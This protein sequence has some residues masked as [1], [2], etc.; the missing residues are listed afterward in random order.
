V[1]IFPT[2]LTCQGIAV[3][4]LC[5]L[6]AP[7]WAADDAA[8]PLAGGLPPADVT[9]TSASPLAFDIPMQPLAA[10]LERYAGIAHLSI[11][12]TSDMVRGRTSSPVQGR[13]SS[14]AALQRLLEG[15]GLV[16]DVHDSGAGK[17]Y[18]L[19]EVDKPAA[20]PAG[21]STLFSQQGYPGLVQS[22][23]WQALCTNAR[24]A[25][26]QYR[27]LFQ[28]QLDAAGHL[29]DA[30]LLVST[31]DARRD[32]AVL[33]SLQHVQVEPPPPPALVRQSVLMSLLPGSPG[34]EFR[35]EQAR[36]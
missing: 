15:T 30:R 11:V 19:R 24:T 18:L 27:L 23:I 17:T 22:R 12:V 8:A 26:G 1:R 6:V 10:A 20:A 13:Y 28:F 34:T 3:G 25:P 31:G 21:M 2:I 33:D 16:A 32:A 35:C 29:A 4:M 14:Q 7:A 5:G 9:T 36:P